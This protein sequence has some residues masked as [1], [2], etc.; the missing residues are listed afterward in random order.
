MD[1]NK[2]RLHEY[3][4]Y[5]NRENIDIESVR[6]LCKVS[7]VN[8]S[9]RSGCTALHEYL[10][11]CRSVKGKYKYRYNGY[12]KFYASGDYENYNYN[13]DHAID[14]SDD[15]TDN[16][17]N[18]TDDENEK[19]SETDNDDNDTDDEN[20]KPSETNYEY[21]DE[22]QDQNNQLVSSNIKL[23]NGGNDFVNEFYGYD[24]NINIHDYIDKS[25]KHVVYGR[26]TNTRWCDIW[27]C[28]HEG[29]YSIGKECIDNIY[30]DNNTE[31]EFEAID[32][33]SDVTDSE[34][35]IQVT[36]DASTQ[37][38]EKKSELDRYMEAYSRNRYSKHSVFKGFSDEVRKND[39]DMNIVKELLSNGA[40][41]TINDRSHKDPII[42]YF[43]RTIMNLDM[44]DIINDYTT[45][46][47]R[48]YIVHI[49]LNNYRNFDYPFFRKLV[50]TNK[51][52]LTNY[53]SIYG[54]PLHILASN[55]KLI[56]P[57]Y[58]KLLVYNGNDIN[59]RGED[60]Y[61]RTPLHYY[62]HR[63]VYH[64]IEYG[65]GYYN[66][67]IIDAFI[68][69]GA[70]LTITT[71]DD[72]IPVI[73]CI[74]KN[75][76]HG[77]TNTNNIKLI[78]KL[79]NLS[80]HAPYNLFRDR[81]MHDYITNLYTDFECL[82]IIRSLDGFDINCYFNGYTP[83]HCAVSKNYTQIA[84]Y[85][86]DHGAD[87]VLKTEDGKTVF[88]LSLS[89]YIPLRWT[90][91]LISRLPP[92][93]VVD[94]LTNNI[95]D[96]VLNDSKQI[97]WQSSMINRY[98]LLVDPSFYHR[99]RNVLECKI[100]QRPYGNNEKYTKVLHTIEI[101]INDIKLLKSIY[102]TKHTTL[103]DT[104]I[105]KS[106]FPIRYIYH[107]NLINSIKS[108]TYYNFIE[109]TIKRRLEIYN[110][111]HKVIDHM[112]KSQSSYLSRIPNEILRDILHRLEISELYKLYTRY[113]QEESKTGIDNDILYDNHTDN[114]MSISTQT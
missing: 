96:Y 29:V 65:V 72:M 93:C 31:S 90:S 57:N 54:T 98:L 103:Y 51:H 104:I 2:I 74:H 110:L 61:M 14:M 16:D 34:Y 49:Y 9:F 77:Y 53:H 24:C 22:T 10:Y 89:S 95:I 58:I 15:Y 48:K 97:I 18:D 36:K 33:L 19:P 32:I 42:V 76:T 38:W 62:L 25:I 13:Y 21:Y 26:N 4:Y 43:R 83:L 102:V 111:V 88:D 80:R 60:T 94:S 71:D 12:Y 82:D 99:F 91:F 20:E 100:K 50:I 85:L 79:L 107:N 84:E 112:S 59:A 55:K 37:T 39:L 35:I 5:S 101:Y 28:H 30:E 81:V 75:S 113:I 27:K 92:K 69:L 109:Q 66:E 7:D 17:D 56:T 41:M 40:S 114:R 45:I 46:D 6:H 1:N 3:L 64:D 23:T 8:S 68:E 70:D 108:N 52:C 47:E 78:R 63:M 44:I 73:Y 87:I 11:N 105:N 86:L 106:E 67:K